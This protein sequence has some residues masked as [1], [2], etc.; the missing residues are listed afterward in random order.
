VSFL[1][2]F[3]S[4]AAKIVTVP[5]V[6]FALGI[7]I[8]GLLGY[9]LLQRGAEREIHENAANTLELLSSVRRF[10]EDDAHSDS[11]LGKGGFVHMGS[12]ATAQVVR[13]YESV[14]RGEGFRYHRVALNPT[15]SGNQPDEVETRLIHRLGADL[16]LTQTEDEVRLKGVGY[17]VLAT[18]IVVAQDRCLACHGSPKGAPAWRVKRFGQLAGFGWQKGQVVGIDVVYTPS[19][20]PRQQAAAIFWT[21]AR[22]I[23]ILAAICAILLLVRAHLLISRPVYRMLSAS[24]SIQKGEW[25]HWTAPGFPDE[26][27]TLGNSFQTTSYMLRNKIIREEKL[28]AL[29]QQFIPASVA[30]TALGKHADEVLIG[31][32][33]P[34][35]VMIINIRN[36]KLLMDHLPPEQTVSTLNEYFG[37]VNKIIVANKGLVSKYMG[38]SVIALFG[39]PLSQDNHALRAVRS[40]ISI[41]AAL[42]D[43]YVRLD[44]KHGWELGVG[45]GIS[46]G[47]P[48]IG[49]FG[50]SEHFEYTVLGDV[51]GEAEYLEATTKAVP[52]EDSILISEATYR[53]VMSDVHVL[54]L[55]EK[56]RPSGATLHAYVVQGLRSEVRSSLAA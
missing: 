44:E 29:F 25:A 9:Q 11:P 20:Y 21:T 56:S 39:M 35:T 30:A 22:A 28:R 18:P 8:P 16:R 42:Q 23:G 6:A 1:A 17:H 36:F 34:V 32:R 51:V 5:I 50:S 47:E 4:V 27:A 10:A 49:S 31:T 14:H 45:I 43:L 46:T 2:F 37:A 40:A 53:M 52:E 26:L 12:L 3:R 7:L 54:D 55:G 41:P 24:E 38:D 15:D 19:D 13:R 33:H 48:I